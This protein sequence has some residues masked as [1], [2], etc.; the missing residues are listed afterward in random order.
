[1]SLLVFI[2]FLVYCGCDFLVVWCK[3]R[4]GTLAFDFGSFVVGCGLLMLLLF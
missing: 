4:N 3:T 1:M 2:V